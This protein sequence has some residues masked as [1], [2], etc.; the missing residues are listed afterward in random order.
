MKASYYNVFVPYNEEYILFNTQKGSLFLIDS[1]VKDLLEK[2]ELSSFDEE[3]IEVLKRNG[4]LVDDDKNER[5]TVA[6]MLNKTRHDKT[7][8]DF[9]IITTYECNVSCVHCYEKKETKRMD[10]K[11]AECV[12]EFIKGLTVKSSRLAIT[13]FGGEPL[14]NMAV[15]LKIAKKLSE[16]CKETQ[17]EFSLSVVTNGTL[18]TSENI[19]NLAVY[20]CKVVVMLDGPKDIHDQR[21][22]Y[23]NGKGTFNDI[24]EGLHQATDYNLDVT[25]RITVDDTNNDHIESLLKFLKDDNLDTV[26]ISIK[27]TF[28]TSPACRWYDCVLAEPWSKV[29]TQ[30]VNKAQDMNFPVDQPG[31]PSSRACLARNI[32]YFTIDPYLRLFKCTVLVPYERNA[33]G[34]INT[35]DFWPTFNQLNI[36]FLSRDPLLLHECRECNLVPACLG[37]CPAHVLEAEGTTH[38]KVC[39]KPGLYEIVK[40]YAN[41]RGT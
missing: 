40:N 3:F 18:L 17:K 34:T 27:P 12:I 24:L 10:E 13:F 29:Q 8:L 25:V 22:R 41:S 5:D 15:N 28:N 35:K 11:S 30:L 7:S 38:G 6:L 37:G 1:Q 23:K 33:V 19:E 4:I 14:L 9:H 20:N 21:R 26:R 32:S 16:W 2:N 39:D 31:K 36:D